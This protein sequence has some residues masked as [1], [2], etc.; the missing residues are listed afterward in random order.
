MVIADIHYKGAV[1]RTQADEYVE[2]VNRGTAPGDISGWTLFADDPGQNFAFPPNTVLQPGQR[3]RI[4]TNEVHPEWGGY[5]Y[6][7]GRPLWN[8]KGDTA[9]LRDTDDTVVSDYSY[10]AG[11]P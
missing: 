2:I 11:A 3:I 4:Y 10:G 7:S 6:G 5:L 8:D 1:K 9:R